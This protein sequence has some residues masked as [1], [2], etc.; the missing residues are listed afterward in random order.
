MVTLAVAAVALGIAI[1]SFNQ[2]MLNNRSLTL[3][4]E[5]SG[6]VNYARSEAVKRAKRVSI[7]ASEDGKTCLGVNNWGKGWL[8]FVDNAVS[9][10]GA[11]VVE[12]VLRYWDDLPAKTNVSA[13]KGV[14]INIAYLRFTATGTLARLGASDA[15]PRKFIAYVQGCKGKSSMNI[16]IGLAGIVSTQN[17]NCP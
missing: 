17:I 6:A 15:D 2:A 4:T 3:G 8:V 9:D 7:C 11:V 16:G 14:S 13:I 10:S 12:T 1:P 5:L